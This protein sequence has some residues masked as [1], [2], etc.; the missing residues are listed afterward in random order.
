M[1]WKSGSTAASHG[2]QAAGY[3]D[4]ANADFCCRIATWERAVVL[5]PGNGKYRVY[6]GADLDPQDVYLWRSALALVQW[7]YDHKLLTE[8]DPE[9]P[10]EAEVL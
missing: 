1:D 3:V 5:L 2:I 6:A 10:E 9:N 8:T 4:L 7:R